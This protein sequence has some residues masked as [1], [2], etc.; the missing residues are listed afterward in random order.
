[1]QIRHFDWTESVRHLDAEDR[2]ERDDGGG[3]LKTRLDAAD[4]TRHLAADSAS[5]DST[6]AEDHSAAVMADLAPSLHED[7]QFEVNNGPV[8]A[9]LQAAEVSRFQACVT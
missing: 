8:A 4:E 3:A 5:I 2:C 9:R 7:E 6:A 1:M